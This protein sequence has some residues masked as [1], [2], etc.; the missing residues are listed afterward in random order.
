MLPATVIVIGTVGFLFWKWG[1]R[2]PAEP[3]FR[4][5][6]VNQDGSVRELSPEERKY[7]SEEFHGGDSGRP[8]IKTSYESHD[9]WGSKSGFIP[10]RRV[11]SRME[12]LP[13]HP[14]YDAAVK[15]LG[16]DFLGA[17]H[18]AGDIMIENADGSITCYPNSD[19]SRKAHR[20]RFKLLRDYVLAEQR[21]SEALAKYHE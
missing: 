20:A 10:R 11:P 6:Y 5:V 7:L 21:R 4:F 1:P 2:R 16:E 3:G 15:E 14:N 13:V 19:N 8:Y 9:G 12:I 18:A 17:H